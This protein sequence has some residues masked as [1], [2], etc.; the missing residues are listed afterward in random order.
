M[1]RIDGERVP[2][3]EIEAWKRNLKSTDKHFLKKLAIIHGLPTSHQPIAEVAP[4]LSPHEK[5]ERQL[6]KL[7]GRR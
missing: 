5:L 1:A 6:R 2:A 7:R 4:E 3:Y